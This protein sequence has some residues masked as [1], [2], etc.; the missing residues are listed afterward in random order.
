MTKTITEEL[1]QHT[2]DR[3]KEMKAWEQE[4]YACDL[5]HH[6]FNEDMYIIGNYNARQW[7][8]KHDLDVF[9]MIDKV[10]Q[11]EKYNFGEVSTDT[12]SPEKVVNM[13]VYI[14]GEE[15]LYETEHIH[16]IWNGE[17]TTEDYDK[18][19]KELS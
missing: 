11:Y 6:I 3:L 10:V 14:E 8:K 5:H 12:S 13:F 16:D 4:H 15:I 9:T 19:I 7:I 17:C 18:I 1:Y 2:I